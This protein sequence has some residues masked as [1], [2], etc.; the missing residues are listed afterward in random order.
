MIEL[1]LSKVE[2]TFGFKKVLDADKYKQLWDCVDIIEHTSFALLK[3]VLLPLKKHY[4][5][6]NRQ[7]INN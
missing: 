1:S 6:Y 2:K 7:I 4:K 3:S 5:N